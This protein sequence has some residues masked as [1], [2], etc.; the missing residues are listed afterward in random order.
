MDLH[1]TYAA[2]TCAIAEARRGD[3]RLYPR[4]PYHFSV[5]YLDDPQLT[6]RVA[7]LPQLL[8]SFLLFLVE[9]HSQLTFPYVFFMEQI[10]ANHSYVD[11]SLVGDDNSVGCITDLS[12]CCFIETIHGDWYFPDGSRVLTGGGRIRQIY[13]P[14][15]VDLINRNGATSPTGIY[16]CDIPTVAVHD[17]ADSSVR[18][19]LYVGLYLS[20][21]G[22]L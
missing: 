13:N 3:A 1:R 9:V 21:G 5:Q 15:S 22:N 8:P 16:R 10:L 2:V 17:D 4:T 20:N 18:D 19:T 6:M 12:T 7:S 11:L 14:R